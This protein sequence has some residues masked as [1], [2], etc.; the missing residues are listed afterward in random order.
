M[1]SLT[2]VYGG[3]SQ[4][5]ILGSTSAPLNLDV[6]AQ[7]GTALGSSLNPSIYGNA[8]QLTA[9][10]M[11]DNAPATTGTVQFNDSGVALG[12]VDVVNGAAVLQLNTLAAGQHSISAA[13]L[14][15]AYSAASTSQVLVQAVN[16]TT[17]KTM[18]S[19]SP[20]P[21]I[22]GRAVTLQAAVSVLTGAGIPTGRV[23]FSDGSTVLGGSNLS[24]SGMATFSVQLATGAHSIV[25]SYAGDANNGA[26]SSATTILQVVPATTQVN[27]STSQ[28]PIVADTALTITAHVT[29]NGGTPGG[30]VSFLGD[31][32]LLG[33]AVLDGTGT[34]AYSIS[35]LALGTHTL[36]VS[37]SG[38]V[39]DA[40]STS[41]PVSQ[42]VGP[43]HT[44]TTIGSVTNAQKN[45]NLLLAA[46]VVGASGPAP[47]GVVDFVSSGQVI[48]SA[49]L[50]AS[51]VA[52]LTPD[53]NSG[54]IT[55]SAKY[56][57]DAIHAASQS[58]PI[59]V[60]T[61]GV[62]FNVLGPPSITMATTQN[63]T[64]TI[65]LQSTNGFTDRIGLGCAGL[66]AM[67][68]CHFSKS[69]TMLNAN[70]IAAVQLTIDTNAPISGGTEVSAVKLHGGISM[71]SAAVPMTVV[72]GLLLRCRRRKAA[73]LLALALTTLCG[74]E[75]CAGLSANSVTPGTYAVQI[76]AAGMQ[77]DVLRTMNLSVNVT[78]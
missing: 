20:D 25:A 65:T 42:T 18:V 15:N 33:S 19:S 63:A 71:A 39:N 2:A 21:A 40:G 35:T 8:V 28:N 49:A 45:A 50:N 72:W 26:D 11:A 70:G 12:S 22:G 57:G 1:H 23:I 55:V 36:T 41:L 68:T 17:T 74:L 29:G 44:V 75:G 32:S 59:S 54:S 3:A 58:E 52:T 77:T 34:A 64:V 5:Y 10:V 61:N 16:R 62:G 30:S 6:Q 51:G 24:G 60:T 14:A 31:G 67:M 47:T 69:D 37:Y 56:E 4:S 73:A 53:V 76:T 27:L 38:D 43:I 48:G 13:Y 9:T 7:S 78:R 66:P 46:T